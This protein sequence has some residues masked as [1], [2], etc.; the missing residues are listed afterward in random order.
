MAISTGKKNTKTGVSI[1]PS[2]NPE[3]KV[4]MAVRKAAIEI[5]IISILYQNYCL[6]IEL[7]I[8]I[9]RLLKFL[10]ITYNFTKHLFYQNV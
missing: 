8:E 4:R 3:K 10:Q 6:L 1:V 7:L 9:F 2:P 5:I